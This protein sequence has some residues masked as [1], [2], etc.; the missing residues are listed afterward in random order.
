MASAV[1]EVCEVCTRHVCLLATSNQPAYTVLHPEMNDI[2]VLMCSAAALTLWLS[3]WHSGSVSPASH[4]VANLFRFLQV[5]FLI[6]HVLSR[7]FH[8][9]L[10]CNQSHPICLV[11]VW[12]YLYAK[13]T[14]SKYNWEAPPLQDQLYLGKDLSC[15]VLL[16]STDKHQSNVRVTN[17][18]TSQW[19][20]S[21]FILGSVLKLLHLLHTPGIP[22]FFFAAKPLPWLRK[23][24][25]RSRSSSYMGELGGAS[26][27]IITI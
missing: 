2:S 15:A 19:Q 11:D 20:T 3:P 10:Y 25:L 16:Y 26:S 5:F 27:R 1:T 23:A 12:R 7:L 14:L 4:F 17:L 13:L 8:F 18:F 21:R 24:L 9:A 22:L 6:F